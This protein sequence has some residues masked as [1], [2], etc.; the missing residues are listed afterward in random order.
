VID[1]PV[2]GV[3]G[4]TEPEYA[5]KLIQEGQVDL[6]AVGRGLLNDPDWAIKANEFRP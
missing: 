6:V 2:I 4:I 3:G 5:N 1:I